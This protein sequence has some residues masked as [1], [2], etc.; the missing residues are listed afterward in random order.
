MHFEI[1]EVKAPKRRDESSGRGDA[2]HGIMLPARRDR[3]R[4]ISE[5]GPSTDG[6]RVSWRF[7]GTSFSVCQMPG[8]Q[9]KTSAVP[10]FVLKHIE[11]GYD[12]LWLKNGAP[13]GPHNFYSPNVEIHNFEPYR[14]YTAKP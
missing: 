4:H 13:V 8:T 10:A 14:P 9:W 12:W 2:V 5:R 11:A 1:F 7:L 6:D 3:G